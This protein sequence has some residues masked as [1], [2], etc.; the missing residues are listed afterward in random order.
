MEKKIE[1]SESTMEDTPY[2]QTEKMETLESTMEATPYL[3]TEVIFV[4]NMYS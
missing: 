2:Q 4:M 3:Q 1:T